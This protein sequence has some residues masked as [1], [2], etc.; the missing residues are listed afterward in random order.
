[1]KTI[2]ISLGDPAGIGPEIVVRALAERPDA[3]VLVFGDIGLLERAAKIVGVAVPDSTRIRAVTT[4][5]A[6]E[7]TP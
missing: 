4:L 1:M 7:V 3:N 5:R 6:D 2:A